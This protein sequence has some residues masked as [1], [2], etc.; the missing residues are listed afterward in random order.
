MESWM[1]YLI[2]FVI[3]AIFKGISDDQKKKQE[4]PTPTLENV[5]GDLEEGKQLFH[6]F[7]QPKQTQR[8]SA[9]KKPIGYFSKGRY[10]DNEAGFD[11]GADYDLVAKDYDQTATDYDA[12]SNEKESEDQFEHH[13]FGDHPEVNHKKTVPLTTT[14]VA[15]NAKKKAFQTLRDPENAR[16]ALILSEILGQPKSRKR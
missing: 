10:F 1:F 6:Q 13:R 4:K 9:N 12:Y 3:W 16:N 14:K 7:T 2:G 5:T 8:L 11:T 15:G